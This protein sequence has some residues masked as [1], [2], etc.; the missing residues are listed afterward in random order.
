MF[1]H[2][3]LLQKR[4]QETGEFELLETIFDVCYS[5]NL[6]L[7]GVVGYVNRDISNTWQVFII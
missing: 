5:A 2:S 4:Q 1:P 3:P 6:I 7:C